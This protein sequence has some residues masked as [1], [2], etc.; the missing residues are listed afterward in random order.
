MFD[1]RSFSRWIRFCLVML[2]LVTV[3]YFSQKSSVE[4]DLQ[5]D[6][7]LRV[8]RDARQCVTREIVIREECDRQYRLISDQMDAL[9]RNPMV[10]TTQEKSDLGRLHEDVAVRYARQLSHDILVR[11]VGTNSTFEMIESLKWLYGRHPKLARM[12][13]MMSEEEMRTVT[14]VELFLAMDSLKKS[15]RYGVP[16]WSDK[17]AYLVFRAKTSNISLDQLGVSQKQIREIKSLEKR[18]FG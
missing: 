10:I 7:V 14:S 6:T 1:I 5:R 8:M 18:N 17:L 3:H 15:W 16:I 9:R 2:L 4:V 13:N 11:G 12:K